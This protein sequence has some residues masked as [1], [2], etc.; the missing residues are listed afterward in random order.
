MTRILIIDDHQLFGESLAALLKEEPNVKIV[1]T[2]SRI[3]DLENT[4]S[5]LKPTL[6]LLDLNLN[7]AL[8]G[9]QVCQKITPRFPEIKVLAISMHHEYRH[10]AGM[11]KAGAM[12][13]LSKNITKKEVLKAIEIVE[14]GQMYYE[15]MIGKILRSESKVIEEVNEIDLNPKE[16][17]ILAGVMEGKTSK[18]IAQEMGVSSRTVEFYRGGLLVK[19]GAKNVVELINKLSNTL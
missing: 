5:H 19:F 1:G 8:N 13:Y 7:Q 12:G 17:K 14:K 4:I 3:G 11:K 15:G 2:T 9:I 16:K 10:I 18:E 6:I